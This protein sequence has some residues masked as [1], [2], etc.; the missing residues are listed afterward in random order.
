MNYSIKCVPGKDELCLTSSG[1]KLD[2]FWTLTLDYVIG[3]LLSYVEYTFKVC[4][5]NDVSLSNEENGE[6]EEKTV[7]TKQGSK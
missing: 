5:N 7:Q 4:S 6:C 1:Q 2:T 3:D